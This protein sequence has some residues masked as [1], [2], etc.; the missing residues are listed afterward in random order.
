[1]NESKIKKINNEEQNNKILQRKTISTKS[2]FPSRPRIWYQHKYHC[3][4][5]SKARPEPYTKEIVTPN[6][7]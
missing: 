6:K 1:M 4:S 7:E 2:Y 5:W 3:G